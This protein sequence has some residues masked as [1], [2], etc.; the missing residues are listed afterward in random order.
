LR[1]SES[2]VV[3]R[4]WVLKNSVIGKFFQLLRHF[5]CPQWSA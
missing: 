2:T 3:N 5:G 1:V 4:L